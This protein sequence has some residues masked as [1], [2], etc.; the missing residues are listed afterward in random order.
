MYVCTVLWSSSVAQWWKRTKHFP[1]SCVWW[2]SVMGHRMR[3]CTQLSAMLLH[4]ISSHFSELLAKLIGNL[5]MIVIIL[6]PG[7][8]SPAHFSV[9]T[10]CRLLQISTVHTKSQLLRTVM[11]ERFRL[12]S[13]AHWHWKFFFV[14]ILGN[15]VLVWVFVNQMELSC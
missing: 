1:L 5:V 10:H 4:H 6:S 13:S 7:F 8:V 11:S 12:V 9:I 2:A 14:A 3:L 15:W